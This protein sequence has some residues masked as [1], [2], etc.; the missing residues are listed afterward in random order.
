M[1][2]FRS[3]W[4]VGY[5]ACRTCSRRARTSGRSSCARFAGPRSS[6]TLVFP[7]F[8]ASS[9]ELVPA[10]FGEQWRDAADVIPWIA[11]STLILGSISVAT[12][13]LPRR[14]S[15]VRAWW[16][17]R[18]RPSGSCGSRSRLLSFPSWASPRSASATS[19]VRLSRS[20]SFDRATR[21][22]RGVAPY[23]AAPA[24]ARGGAW[25]RAPWAGSRARPVPPG[26]CDGRRRRGAHARA[27]LAGLCLVVLAPT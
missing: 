14:P 20:R 3:L 24:A 21:R 4:A 9:P 25:S 13:R 15:G 7:A 17:G 5:P 11:L 6:A 12:E 16:L 27:E 23:S 10:L 18:R 19:A 22:Q 8:A 2:A 1:L 26:I